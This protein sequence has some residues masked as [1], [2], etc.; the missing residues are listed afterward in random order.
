MEHVHLVGIGGSGLSAIATLLLEQGNIVSGSD[1]QSSQV[2]DRLAAAGAEVFIGHRARQ[3][4]GADVI[5]VSSAIPE[6]NPEICAAQIADIPVLSRR[7]FVGSLMKGRLGVAV[8]GTHG[9]TT[10]AAL[11]SYLLHRA[12]LD[13]SFIVGGLI[14][15]LLTSARHGSGN[16]FVV[17]ADEYDRM[18]LGLK[19][20]VAIITNIEY[21]HPDCYATLAE[22]QNAFQEFTQLLPDDGVLIVARDDPGA[23]KLGRASMDRGLE[24]VTYSLVYE[25]DWRAANITANNSGGCDFEV[26]RGD[27]QS[28]CS[29]SSRLAGRHNVENVL[30]VFAAAEHMGLR[31]DETVEWVY[32][33]SGVERRFDVKGEINNITVVDDYAH[34]PTEIRATLASARLHYPGRCIWALFQ[35]HTFSRTK[36]MLS[37]FASSFSDA[38]HVV[39][40]DIFGAREQ[41]NASVSAH[42]IV[43][44]MEHPDAQ[45][46][47]SLEESI[48]V[49]LAGI[50]SGDVLVTLGA[51]NSNAVAEGVLESLRDPRVK[52]VVL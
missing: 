52:E 29:V 13:P 27:G 50:R 35:P 44:M 43:D 6:S 14:T 49:L 47:Q 33:F 40:T 7:E 12:G 5:L 25:A 34:H 39:V 46:V 15:N 10:T 37:H 51:G 42:D 41:D 9:K 26:F 2:T 16:P 1:S 22:M 17:E 3:I 32:E 30:A 4:A 31:I 28:G 11:L 8:A 36:V 21:D 20:D 19:P 24:V 18:F 48:R 45:H 23:W 38:D